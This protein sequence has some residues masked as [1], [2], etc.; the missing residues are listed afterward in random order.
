MFKKSLALSLVSVLLTSTAQACLGGSWLQI[1][2]G[3]KTVV[4][5]YD[6]TSG[7]MLAINRSYAVNKI[8]E[9]ISSGP[10]G[11]QLRDM[12]ADGQ[13]RQI[14]DINN[15][16]ILVN[17][18]RYDLKQRRTVKSVKIIKNVTIGANAPVKRGMIPPGTDFNPLTVQSCSTK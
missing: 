13:C 7:R 18:S 5:T 14:D 17:Y 6:I 8:S 1:T 15:K 9:I 16:D 2:S 3:S 11:M 4:A 10:E 12:C